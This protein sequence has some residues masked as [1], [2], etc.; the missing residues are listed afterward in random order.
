MS[1]TGCQGCHTP[2]DFDV[3]MAFQPI[4]D[5][6]S[7]TVYA[8]EALVRGTD[9]AG[10]AS[11]LSRV[12]DQNRYAFDQRCRVRAVEL[13]AALH[14]D[15]MLSINF[16]PN[17]VYEPHR[18]LQTTIAAARRTGFPVERI[19][20]ETVENERVPDPSYLKQIFATYHDEGFKTAIDDFGAG[21]A[22]LSLL[23][24]F[25]PD[26]VK[27]DMGLINNVAGDRARQ[28]IVG[29]L[30][31]VGNLL[32]IDVIAEGVERKS[33]AVVL[34][35]LGIRLMQGYLFAKPAFEALP[36]VDFDVLLP[37]ADQARGAA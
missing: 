13:A 30:A 36:E 19:I 18:C 28:T 7:R 2:L 32:G 33:D 23:A 29:A 20:F 14:M 34:H 22:G 1:A 26:I 17:A 24:D 8:Y 11:V 27:I 25:Q 9:G 31:A 5:V 10:A 35:H 12:N 3:S 16:M 15:A 37:L 21:Y 6:E 4:V